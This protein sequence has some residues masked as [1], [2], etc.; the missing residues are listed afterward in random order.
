MRDAIVILGPALFYSLVAWA[1]LVFLK[2]AED[3]M[4]IAIGLLNT[5]F[6]GTVAAVLYLTLLGYLITE[7][8]RAFS[9]LALSDKARTLI[10]IAFMDLST[11]FCFAYILL[12]VTQIRVRRKLTKGGLS[13]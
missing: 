2:K 1:A 3:K 4:Q 7:N 8:S 13:E 9:V 5:I 10:D 6:V 11:I 12:G